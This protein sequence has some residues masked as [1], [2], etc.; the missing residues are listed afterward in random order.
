MAAIAKK[1]QE[2]RCGR[3]RR[4]Q[5]GSG[6]A[7]EQRVLAHERVA[8][9]SAGRTDLVNG[10]CWVPTST[11]TRPTCDIRSFDADDRNRLI[12]VKTTNGWE[13]TPFHVTRN[14]LTV[15]DERRDE[16]CLVRLWNFARE[17]KAFELRPPLEARVS[18]VATSFQANFL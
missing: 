8:L 16:W 2:V 11:A 7:G 10:I 13:R 9:L 1:Y 17:P 4:A 12:E 18:L 14:E 3:A 15:A 5:P 6:K